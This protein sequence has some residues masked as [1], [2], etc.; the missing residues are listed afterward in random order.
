MR[1]ALSA[2]SVFGA[3]GC[4]L[5]T[6]DEG[7]SESVVQCSSGSLSR[8]KDDETWRTV[9]IIVAMTI[10]YCA[11]SPRASSQPARYMRKYSSQKGHK[12]CV[13]IK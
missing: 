8:V 3:F 5:T 2:E 1:I 10:Q 6:K 12:K 7:T 11:R 13:H 4:Q 9:G